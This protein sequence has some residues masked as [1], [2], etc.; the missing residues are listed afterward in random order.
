[1]QSTAQDFILTVETDPPNAQVSVDG[2]EARSESATFMVAAGVHVIRITCSGYTPVEMQVDMTASKFL[3]I[4]LER[5]AEPVP[6]LASD[7]IFA[8]NPLGPVLEPTP[9][10]TPEPVAKPEPAA[11]PDPWAE[12]VAES[13]PTEKPRPAVSDNPLANDPAVTGRGENDGADLSGRF[14]DDAEVVTAR[15]ESGGGRL[16][17]SWTLIGGGVAL[18]AGGAALAIIGA[19]AEDDIKKHESW[20]QTK[21]NDEWKSMQSRQSWGVSLACIGGAAITG[22][23]IWLVAGRPSARPDLD[24]TM[25]V[26]PQADGASV[27]WALSF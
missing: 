11:E 25:F 20:S 9:L 4:K 17:G 24:S 14:A 21:A 8:P 10:S 1:L 7:S 12:P 19:Q 23:I 5:Q 13:E 27:G 26:V 18:A 15:N 22:G 16:A 2:G 6:D 3:T